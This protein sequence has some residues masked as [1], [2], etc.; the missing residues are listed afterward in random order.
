MDYTQYSKEA[1]IKRIEQLERLNIALLDEKEDRLEF[2]WTGSL[3]RWY[4]DFATGT[5]VFNPLKI[6]T[7]GYSMADIPH[8]TPYSFFTQLIH[9][10]DYRDTML[11]MRDHMDNKTNV[12]EC[13]YRIRAS[14]GHYKWYYD[15]GTV[16]Q[17]DEDGK[18]L[19]AV[20]IVFDITNK[21]N[22]EQKLMEENKSLA[23]EAS[24]DPLTGIA[25]RRFLFEELEQLVNPH[26]RIQ[27]PLSIILFDID[28]FKQFNDDYGHLA[29]DKVLKS[30]ANELN[31]SIRGFDTLGRYGGEEFLI[32]LPN[33]NLDKALRAAERARQSIEAL[34]ID[35]LPKVTISGG[36]A[37]REENE[38]IETLIDRADQ[39]LYQAKNQG[40]NQIC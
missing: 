7:L 25:N 33:T 17:R 37:Q 36:V 10:D 34:V 28:N 31:Q 8:P 16:T 26:I 35:G 3:G 21:K 12:Y 39:K 20:G 27:R 29:G 19:F 4:L 32:I 13:E 24:T 23:I 5:V 6:E 30:V 38:S 9:P 2:G 18:A 40:R 14:N 15:R 1:L 22:T 11:A